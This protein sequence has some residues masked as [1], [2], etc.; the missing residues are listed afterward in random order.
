MSVGSG[1]VAKDA[2]VVPIGDGALLFPPQLSDVHDSHHVNSFLDFSLFP[3]SGDDDELFGSG[4]A[5]GFEAA[6]GAT[7]SLWPPPQ[8]PSNPLDPY[9]YLDVSQFL[10]LHAG[11]G[12]TASV[13]DEP[14]TAA[15]EP[16]PQV[17]VV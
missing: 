16:D 8:Q 11:S 14:G 17:L 5:P 1:R 9:E 4:G 2:A 7:D 15:T 10:D 13:S 6:G 12:A 3:D